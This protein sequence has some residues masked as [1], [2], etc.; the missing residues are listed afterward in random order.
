MGCIG[1]VESAFS[2]RASKD[3]CLEFLS[4]QLKVIKVPK[5]PGAVKMERGYSVTDHLVQS[6]P[7]AAFQD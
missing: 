2:M 1:Q 3:T 7:G 6:N 4:E 5:N